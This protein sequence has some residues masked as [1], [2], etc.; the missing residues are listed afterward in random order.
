[1]KRFV[2]LLLLLTVMAMTFI[3][4]TSTDT[5]AETT[6][7]SVESVESVEKGEMDMLAGY[8]SQ[9]MTAL[10]K[11]KADVLLYDSYECLA[12]KE[13]SNS[14]V[15]LSADAQTVSGVLC[16]ST[17]GALLY[18]HGAS[19][20]TI[21]DASA[22]LGKNEEELT[23]AYGRFHFDSGSGRY[24][25]AYIT[26]HGELLVFSFVNDV[27]CSISALKLSDGTR[28]FYE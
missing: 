23:A 17:G 21:D 5:A 12:W 20:V 28:T 8:L 19:A 16:F 22:L 15:V 11:E 26:E 1:M 24:L 7:V 10:R 2:V 13:D 9:D 27:V 6:S 25:P 18:R 14:V 4:C 3:G